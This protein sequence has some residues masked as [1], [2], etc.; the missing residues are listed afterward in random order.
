LL[1]VDPAHTLRV[2]FDGHA[3]HS[4]I[5]EVPI[6]DARLRASWGTRLYR[7]LLRADSP[8]AHANWTL[9]ITGG[10]E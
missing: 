7:I 2:L 1:A 10:A 6:D 3:L 9:R 4:T 8:P 5:E